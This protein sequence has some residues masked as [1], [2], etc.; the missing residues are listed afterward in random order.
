MAIKFLSSLDLGSNA[1]S[2]LVVESGNTLPTGTV[3][4]GRLYQKG[5]DMFYYNGSAFEQL[6]GQSF[7]LSAATSSALGGIKIGATN[8]QSK[9]YAV[10]LDASNAAFVSVPWTDSSTGTL[11]IE[12]YGTSVVSDI[13]GGTLDFKVVTDIDVAHSGTGDLTFNLDL[14]ELS[15][16]STAASTDLLSGVFASGQKSVQGNVAIS[17]ITLDKFGAPAADLAMNSKKITGLANG[18]TASQDAATVAQM[19]S[20]ISNAVTNGTYA[21]ITAKGNF[22]GIF[23]IDLEPGD[24]IICQTAYAKGASPTEANWVEVQTNLDLVDASASVKGIASFSDSNFTV[25]SGD[26]VMTDKLSAN[27]TTAGSATKTVAVTA[28]KQG[29]ITALG[30]QDIAIPATQVTDFATE[31]TKLITNREW[32]GQATAGTGTNVHD[33]AHGL[34]SESVVA[35][36]WEKSTKT[37]VMAEIRVKDTNTCQVVYA[38]NVT[39]YNLYELRVTLID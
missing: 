18:A 22:G 24:L 3:A 11:A 32:V 37:M 15:T 2:G 21:M 19:E 25:S 38:E 13:I 35:Q 27:S 39:E 14:T 29:I 28:N 12:V 9:S 30:D 10:Q 23:S 31:G 36:L 1:V 6:N 34:K 26:V 33:F 16:G 7:Q 17:T 8:L 4:T 20:A 5:A